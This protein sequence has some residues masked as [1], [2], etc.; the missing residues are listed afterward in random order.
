V[1]TPG[2]ALGFLPHQ[3]VLYQNQVAPMMDETQK[4]MKDH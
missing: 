1:C 4:E 3:I 2:E